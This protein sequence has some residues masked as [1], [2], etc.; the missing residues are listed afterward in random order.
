[1]I[2][3]KPIAD[4]LPW[5][6]IDSKF[7]PITTHHLLTHTSGLPGDAPVFLSDPAA[8]HRAA[9]APGERFNYCNLG[10]AILGHLVWNS[11]RPP[12]S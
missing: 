7:A 4:Y 5:L 8:K 11:G 6:R 10:F 1:M 2:S 3:N 12:I 9:Y